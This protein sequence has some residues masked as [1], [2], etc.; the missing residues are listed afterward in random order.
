M[1]DGLIVKIE[2]QPCLVI[3]GVEG[4]L[5][6]EAKPC[7]CGELAKLTANEHTWRCAIQISVDHTSR[8]P[9]CFLG[10][11]LAVSANGCRIHQI[12]VECTVPQLCS[13]QR[14]LQCPL[15]Q[16]AH[17]LQLP[18]EAR[19]PVQ[20]CFSLEA[21]RPIYSGRISTAVKMPHI[22]AIPGT[23]I[24]AIGSAGMGERE[25][26]PEGRSILHCYTGAGR[27]LGLSCIAKEVLCG[28]LLLT[29]ARF[30]A[31]WANGVATG[32]LI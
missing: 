4:Q 23:P 16:P 22:V 14:T 17:A 18:E 10:Y 28:L 9:G 11:L 21:Y 2:K 6:H 19:S 15:W 31:E 32:D 5:L 30:R 20:V 26:T 24:Q 7:P 3:A 25:F 13:W 1:L 29:L 12:R 8:T 27:R